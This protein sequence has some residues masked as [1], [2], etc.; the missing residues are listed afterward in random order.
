[1]FSMHCLNSYVLV[2]STLIL[3]LIKHKFVT[4]SFFFLFHFSE[5]LLCDVLMALET[6]NC[7]VKINEIICAS[8]VDQVDP[9]SL[10]I[11]CHMTHM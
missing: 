8:I 5:T 1:M 11:S 10:T 9:E 6:K 4:N 2:S 7:K 3:K